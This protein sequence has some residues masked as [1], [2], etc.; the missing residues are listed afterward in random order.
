[1]DSDIT[2]DGLQ[3]L[4]ALTNLN[5]LLADNCPGLSDPVRNIAGGAGVELSTSEEV[6]GRTGHIDWAH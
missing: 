1:M 2:S 6:R 5:W 4:T 3:A